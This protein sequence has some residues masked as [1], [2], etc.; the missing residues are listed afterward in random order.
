MMS[1]CNKQSKRIVLHFSRSIWDKPIV[2]RLIK[3]YNLVFNILKARVLPYEDAILVLEISGE[4]EDYERGMQYLRGSGVKIR[5]L[6][7]DISRDEER[8]THCGECIVVCPSDALSVDRDTMEVLFDKQKC[9]ACELCI[10]VCPPR[11]MK[12]FFG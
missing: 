8:C 1:G 2:Y 5:S 3:D 12:L 11:A 7:Q 9:V 6:A 10:P 4:N